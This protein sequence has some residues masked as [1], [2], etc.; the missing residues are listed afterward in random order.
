M[1]SIQSILIGMQ[2]SRKIRL[3]MRKQLIKTDLEITQLE[4]SEGIKTATLTVF[5]VFKTGAI[6][7]Q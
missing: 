1:S 2:R 5:H 6:A 3:M 4:L 7:Q